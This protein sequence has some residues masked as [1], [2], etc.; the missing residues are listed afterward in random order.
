MGTITDLNRVRMFKELDGSLD[1]D[2]NLVV[3]GRR[4]V[5]DFVSHDKEMLRKLRNDQRKI[6][7][8]RRSFEGSNVTF[9]DVDLGVR[10]GN[11]HLLGQKYLSSD[12]VFEGEEIDLGKVLENIGRFQRSDGS[13][14][15]IN[16]GN[17]DEGGIFCSLDY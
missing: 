17:P 15:N 10:F 8:L 3:K 13:Y 16:K 14:K 4:V 7:A 12:I 6:M 2:R 11:L 5:L 9:I 1:L